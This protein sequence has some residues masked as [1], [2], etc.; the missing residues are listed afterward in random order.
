MNVK[1]HKQSAYFIATAIIVVLIGVWGITAPSPS[2]S[3]NV[4]EGGPSS[5]EH[6][7][8]SELSRVLL[9]QRASERLDI[10]TGQVA[11][12]TI[13]GTVMRTIP[14]SAVIYDAEGNAWTYTNPEPLVFIRAPL[15]IDRIDGERA[16]LVDGP[17]AGTVVVTVGGAL[18]FG[19]EFGV[20]H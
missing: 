16:I 3:A 19:T 2:R 20:G 15:M 11:D 10:Q 14:Y 6:I 1:K 8:G 13:E 12:E 5:V 9:T 4:P 7:E 18:L 17:T